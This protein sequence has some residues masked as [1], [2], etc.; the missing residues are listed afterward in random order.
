MHPLSHA[1]ACH[2]KGA[3][4][5]ADFDTYPKGSDYWAI[6]QVKPCGTQGTKS[7]AA[8]ES[9]TARSLC[10]AGRPNASAPT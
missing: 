5:T 2:R 1:P 6:K 4:P 3:C 9:L 7:S 10:I 8:A